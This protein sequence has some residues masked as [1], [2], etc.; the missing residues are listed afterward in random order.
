M[1]L[2]TMKSHNQHLSDFVSYCNQSLAPSQNKHKIIHKD[3]LSG[4]ARYALSINSIA[5][6][7]NKKML[8]IKLKLGIRNVLEVALTVSCYIRWKGNLSKICR[9]TNRDSPGQISRIHFCW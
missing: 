2:R 1:Q 3:I 7:T 9:K 8:L 6:C 4:Y 5:M